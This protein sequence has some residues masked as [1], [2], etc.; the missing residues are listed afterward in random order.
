[1]SHKKSPASLRELASSKPVVARF[2]QEMDAHFEAGGAPCESGDE[3]CY[4]ELQRL[5]G[6][7]VELLK[8]KDLAGMGDGSFRPKH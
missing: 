6:K 1:M 2:M 3:C 7:T 8:A 4:C 5:L